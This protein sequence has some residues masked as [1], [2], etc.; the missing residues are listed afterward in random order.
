M[1]K[2]RCESTGNP[3]SEDIA[4]LN[5]TIRNL[6]SIGIR[7]NTPPYCAPAQTAKRAQSIIPTLNGHIF[8][9]IPAMPGVIAAVELCGIIKDKNGE[10]ILQSNHRWAK[11]ENCVNYGEK[12]PSIRL[13]YQLLRVCYTRRDD[14]GLQ[15]VIEYCMKSLRKQCRTPTIHTATST[16]Y[17][18]TICTIDHHDGSS[19]TTIPVPQ[20][21]P[22][23]EW[24]S[25]IELAPTRPSNMIGDRCAIPTDAHQTLETLFGE[26]Y[27]EAGAILQ[28]ATKPLNNGNMRQILLWIPTINK[29]LND[30]KYGPCTVAMGYRGDDSF[31]ISINDSAS[32]NR[33][34]LGIVI[35]QTMTAQHD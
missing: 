29:R 4:R 25:L 33:K 14:T 24:Y 27:E 15:T 3:N 18:E 20:G 30:M 13:L 21:T 1:L 6:R 26:G 19:P 17:D 23:N 32:G 10:E 2:R 31:G 7:V 5:T 35:Q 34:S 11:Y 28:Y 9:G 12:P 16:H 22:Y 8:T